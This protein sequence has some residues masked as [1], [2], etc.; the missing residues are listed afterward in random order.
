MEKVKAKGI[1]LS[2]GGGEGV[3]WEEEMMIGLGWRRGGR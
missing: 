3:R 1:G 2:L